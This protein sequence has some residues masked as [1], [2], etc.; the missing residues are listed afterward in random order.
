MTN[1]NAHA[2]PL[3]RGALPRRAA[4]VTGALAGA[5][6]LVGGHAAASGRVSRA[7]SSTSAR[8]LVVHGLECPTHTHQSISAHKSESPLLSDKLLGG[9][10]YPTDGLLTTT[11]SEF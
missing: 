9:V 6:F 5:G 8:R 1:D 2:T 11:H 3:P 4:L 10:E 7:A